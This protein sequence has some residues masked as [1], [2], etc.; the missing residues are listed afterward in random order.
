MSFI[1][2]STGAH[3]L[4]LPS[5]PKRRYRKR[6]KLSGFHVRFKV[7]PK[8]HAAANSYSTLDILQPPFSIQ[9]QLSFRLIS[10]RWI[11]SSR[12]TILPSSP[13][14]LFACSDMD[15]VSLNDLFLT[16]WLDSLFLMETW[17]RSILTQWVSEA[18][19]LK[20]HSLDLVISYAQD[21]CIKSNDNVGISD[22]FL[23]MVDA[24]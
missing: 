20:S 22:H 1:Y 4:P 11:F 7:Y 3:P 9:D 23:F 15:W 16:L 19:H 24:E 10:H 17:I 6:G 2:P 13:S 5:L 18:T 12:T 21:I 8:A 14:G